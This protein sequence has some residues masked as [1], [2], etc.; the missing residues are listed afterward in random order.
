MYWISKGR[1]IVNRFWKRL[2]IFLVVLG[3]GI[4]VMVPDNDAGGISTGETHGILSIRA[5]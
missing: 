4:L 3:P 1:R 2:V 5:R